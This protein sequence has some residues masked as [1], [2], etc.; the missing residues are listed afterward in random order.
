MRASFQSHKALMNAIPIDLCV[1]GMIIAAF[2]R[3]II[4]KQNT[5]PIYNAASIKIEKY[6]N[7]IKWGKKYI[8]KEYPLNQLFWR[9]GGKVTEYYYEFYLRVRI[10]GVFLADWIFLILKFLQFIFTQLFPACL[11]DM[12][13]IVIG[14]QPQ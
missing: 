9:P 8:L 5:L 13:L 7:I 14:K 1:K 11:A 12:G 4:S 10:F 3:S 2:K 6:V